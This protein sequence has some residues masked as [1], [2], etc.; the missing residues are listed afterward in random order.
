MDHMAKQSVEDAW[1]ISVVGKAEESME[2]VK[3]RA[4]TVKRNVNA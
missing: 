1:G 3:Q 4:K 2:S